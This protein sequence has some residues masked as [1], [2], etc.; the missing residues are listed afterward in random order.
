MEQIKMSSKPILTIGIP[1][2][3]GS[4]T[5]RNMLDI[6]LPQCD[7]RVEVFVS[8]NCSTDSTPEI[9][10]QYQ[11][12]YTNVTYSKNETN[13]GTDRNII[14]CFERAAGDFVWLLSDDE[15][16]IEGSIKE[17]LDLIKQHQDLGLI[18]LTTVHFRGKYTG[19]KNCQVRKPIAEKNICTT[20]KNTFMYYAGKDWGFMSSFICNSR[21]YREIDN[22]MQYAGTLWLQSYIHTLCAM[23]D[24]TLIGIVSKPCVGAGIY[25]N[26]ANFDSAQVNGV[27]YKKLLDFMVS[28]V[29][30]DKKQLEDLYCWRMC[31]LG[32]HDVLKEKASGQHKLNKKLLF[33]CMWKYPKAWVTLFPFYLV[34]DWLCID[35]MKLYRKHR[36]IKGEITINRPN[37][38]GNERYGG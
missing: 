6:L 31:L 33:E 10:R 19:A 34:P 8:D 13:I 22:P 30:F 16:A 5:I 37:D 2:Y 24:S 32:R 20:D 17:I 18:Y 15:I 3:N 21:K 23:G 35:A 38:S 12:T 9:I 14:K 1:T 28:D 7:S 36:G 11:K 26:T 25:V 27:A 4:K 29:G